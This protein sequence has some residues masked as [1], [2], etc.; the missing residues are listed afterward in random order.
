MPTDESLLAEVPFFKLLDDEERKTLAEVLEEAS[1]GAG[2][3][4]FKFGAPGDALY[5]IR[6]GRVE[7]SVKDTTGAKVVLAVAEPGD[8]FGELSLLDGGPR[9]ADA[10]ALERVELLVLDRDD[11]LLFFRSEPTAALDMLTEM[12]Q[13]VR[14]S[15]ELVRRRVARN[16]NEEIEDKRTVVEKAADGIASFSGSIPFLFLHLA[17][18]AAWIV[19]NLNV[20]PGLK[21]YDPY[22]FGFLTMVVSLEAIVLSVFVLLSQNRQAAKDRIRGDIE[23]DINLKAELEVAHLHE[24]VDNLNA[25]VLSRLHNIEKAV[26]K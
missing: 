17:A 14:H 23:Y 11:L 3:V 6:K 19:I 18:F 2:E 10:V 16:A 7:L 20:I 24:K 4:L 25:E 22:P 9:T 8:F 21:A 13:R 5:L 15:G 12:G 26:H 1:F